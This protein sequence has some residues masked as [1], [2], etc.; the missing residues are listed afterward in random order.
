[1]Y[2]LFAVTF[3][4][5]VRHH[6]K[7]TC[8]SKCFFQKPWIKSCTWNV[9]YLFVKHGNLFHFTFRLGGIYKLFNSFLITFRVL[10]H[11]IWCTI[12]DAL[13]KDVWWVV[14]ICTFFWPNFF[15]FPNLKMICIKRFTCRNIVFSVSILNDSLFLH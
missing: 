4:T 2:T 9:S 10:L 3:G 11:D 5:C 12:F 14:E 15:S 1:M 7:D 6:G 13:Q 8:T